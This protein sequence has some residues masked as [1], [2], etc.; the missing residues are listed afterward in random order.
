MS[1]LAYVKPFAICETMGS[2]LSLTVRP[3]AQGVISITHRETMG[4]RGHHL[5]PKVSEIFPSLANSQHYSVAQ[6]NSTHN[7]QKVLM[8]ET[9]A[10][11]YDLPRD[12][13]SFA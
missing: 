5:I 7:A 4:T 11:K 13:Y 8:I 2:S 12:S 9:K 3:W 10:G 6:D 1:G